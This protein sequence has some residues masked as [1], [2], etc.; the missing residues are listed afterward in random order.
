[1]SFARRSRVKMNGC[2]FWIQ[3]GHYHS[4]MLP[5]D[6]TPKAFL[7][8]AGLLSV[9]FFFCFFVLPVNAPLFYSVSP[10]RGRPRFFLFAYII[11]QPVIMM[12]RTWGGGLG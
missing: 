11:P 4:H 9:S 7:I 6:K 8:H 3:D 5:P 2:P 1:M 12:R 10:G